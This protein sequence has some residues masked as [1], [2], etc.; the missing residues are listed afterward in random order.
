MSGVVDIIKLI[1]NQNL[2]TSSNIANQVS[3]NY[4]MAAEGIK[5]SSGILN[6]ITSSA[7]NFKQTQIDE[8]YKR[9]NLK[10]NERELNVRQAQFGAELA[11]REK[12]LKFRQERA[13]EEQDIQRDRLVQSEKNKDA[14]GFISQ[15]TR[16]YTTLK[17]GYES[18]AKLYA[19]EL[20]TINRRLSTDYLSL[21]DTE[22]DSLMS[23]ANDFQSKYDLSVSKLERINNSYSTLNIAKDSLINGGADADQIMKEIS[24]F[25]LI[26]PDTEFEERR[27]RYNPSS[28]VNV[29]LQDP[30]SI[31]ISGT[32]SNNNIINQAI[33]DDKRFEQSFMQKQN[34]NSGW[35][36][37]ST[38]DR[39]ARMSIDP[40]YK[41]QLAYFVNSEVR[42]RA[43][44]EAIK[45]LDDK[46]IQLEKKYFEDLFTQYKFG[47]PDDAKNFRIDQSRFVRDYALVGG[48]PED[49]DNLRA[50]AVNY[51]KEIAETASKNPEKVNDTIRSAIDDRFK[52]KSTQEVKTDT[53]GVFSD[54]GNLP[55]LRLGNSFTDFYQDQAP[56]PT[57]DDAYFS[58]LSEEGSRVTNKNLEL[59]KTKGT[60]TDQNGNKIQKTVISERGRRMLDSLTPQEL[61]LN[62]REGR[63]GVYYDFTTG[64]ELD[65]KYIN[66]ERKRILNDIIQRNDLATAIKLISNRD[67]K[68][69]EK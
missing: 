46:K 53:G 51:A 4:N 54:D 16:Q 11:F 47:N 30:Q 63:K 15:K 65:K 59:M 48:T 33:Q 50:S 29:N 2:Q 36:I 28:E 34:A 14:Y 31:S 60:V 10:Q 67:I 49:L 66:E 20:D 56:L 39:I 68:R 6:S 44:Q 23:R 64:R 7:I 26:D 37:I 61:G 45:N 32:P 8:W 1:S 55:A 9:E 27:Q 25:D 58:R 62:V 69:V 12:D 17:D 19:K 57:Q 3:A 24:S 18:E 42:P 43:S 21:S 13:K 41:D 22:R 38:N 35:S 40:R 5:V 52:T